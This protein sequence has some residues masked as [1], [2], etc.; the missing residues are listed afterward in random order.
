MH[1]QMIN[2]LAPIATA[3][4]NRAKT[5]GEVQFDRKFSRD[6]QQ[7][8]QQGLI[9]SSRVCQRGN[10]LPRN[11]QHMCR[12]LG[13]NIPKRQTLRIFVNDVRGDLAINDF[14]KDCHR[15]DA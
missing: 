7:V 4:Q 10:W 9:F 6:E 2:C 5:I 13:I 8:A 1:V 3:I 11:D 14:L 15:D 12:G